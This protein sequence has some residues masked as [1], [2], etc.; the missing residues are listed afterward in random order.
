MGFITHSSLGRWPLPSWCCRRSSSATRGL[1]LHL[2]GM[3]GFRSPS[4]A[5]VLGDVFISL[6][7]SIHLFK[8]NGGKMMKSDNFFNGN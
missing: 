4:G 2:V 8:Q 5:Q 1:R 6:S 7:C 3:G